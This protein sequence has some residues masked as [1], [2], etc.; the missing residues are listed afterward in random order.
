MHAVPAGLGLPSLS[1]PIRLALAR[2]SR[3]RIWMQRVLIRLIFLDQKGDT[4]QCQLVGGR[5][6]QSTTMI[7]STIQFRAQRTHRVT[8]S[9]A[10]W[11]MHRASSDW[12]VSPSRNNLASRESANEDGLLQAAD[13]FPRS[14]EGNQPRYRAAPR[15]TCHSLLCCTTRP[16][17]RVEATLRS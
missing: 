1:R 4:I 2:L 15:R 13:R 11:S 5:V 17:R 7:E 16:R 12:A 3:W 6:Q 14:C 8:P 10:G 9:K